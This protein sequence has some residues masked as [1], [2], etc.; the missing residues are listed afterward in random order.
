VRLEIEPGVALP[1]LPDVVSTVGSGRLSIVTTSNYDD[2]MSDAWR[3]AGARV[4]AVEPMTLEEIFVARVVNS[5]A[6]E[7]A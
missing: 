7:A 3:T 4:F 2:A 5:R 1:V 6:P